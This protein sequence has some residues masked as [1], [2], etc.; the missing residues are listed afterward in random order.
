MNE[1]WGSI[2]SLVHSNDEHSRLEL[3][4][5]DGFHRS[6]RLGLAM[7]ACRIAGQTDRANSLLRAS[8]LNTVLSEYSELNLIQ[9]KQIT[10]Q[11]VLLVSGTLAMHFPSRFSLRH[12]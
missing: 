8:V 1:E 7:R 9:A 11:R 2:P 10:V 6:H 3:V 5:R 12:R 4:D